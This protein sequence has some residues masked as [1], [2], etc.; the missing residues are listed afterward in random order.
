MKYHLLTGATGLLGRYLVRDLL[1]AGVPLAVLVR[2]SKAQ[3]PEDRLEAI[4]AYWERAADRCLPRPV[5]LGGDLCQPGLGLKPHHARWIADHCEAVIHSAA[6][7]TF[8]PDNRGE[9]WQ[10]NVEGARNLLQF[11][12]LGRSAAVSSRLDGLP[13]RLARRASLRKRSGPGPET[14]QRL[15]REQAECRENAPRGGFRDA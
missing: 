2:P 7:M 15:R 10:T 9:P 13:L 14:G 4:M 6:S 8:R 11:L 12:S 1:A 5:V 3:A